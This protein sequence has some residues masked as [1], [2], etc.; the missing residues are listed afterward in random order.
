MAGLYGTAQLQVMSACDTRKSQGNHKKFTPSCCAHS[1][2]HQ[3]IITKLSL[4]LDAIEICTVCEPL[5]P[6][7]RF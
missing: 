7:T 5:L 1:S 2:L 6:N 3:E 4:T